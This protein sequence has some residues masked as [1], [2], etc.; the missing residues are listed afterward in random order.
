MKTLFAAALMLGSIAAP[1]MAQNAPYRAAGTEPFWSLTIDSRSMKFEAPGQ[2]S[3]T[4]ATPRVIHGFAGEIYQSRRISVNTVH[5]ACSDGM[6]DRRYPDTVQVTVDGRRYEGCGGA[7]AAEAPR[8]AIE[9]DWR[10]L[11]IA[12][13]PAVRRTNVTVTFNG[14]RMNGN[15]GCNAFGGSYRFDRGFLSA[16]PLITTKMACSRFINQQEQALLALFGQ[17]LSVTSMRNGN[18]R[19]TGNGGSLVLVREAGRR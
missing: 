10:I 15:T 11:T 13:R 14:A 18:L 19:M 12:G 17:R 3:V 16:G 7:A 2:H 4:V 9:G 6:S 8:S 1:A 5:K